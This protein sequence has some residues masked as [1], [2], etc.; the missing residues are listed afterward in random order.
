[1][2]EDQWSLE[3]IDPGG[4]VGLGLF[5]GGNTAVVRPSLQEHNPTLVRWETYQSLRLVW[6]TGTERSVTGGKT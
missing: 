2:Y 3:V 6:H 5:M 1:M 4:G